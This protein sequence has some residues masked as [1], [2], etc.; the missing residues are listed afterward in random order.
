MYENYRIFL[1]I[2]ER[3]HCM[4]SNKNATAIIGIILEIYSTTYL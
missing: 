4:S 2:P 3:T 1:T